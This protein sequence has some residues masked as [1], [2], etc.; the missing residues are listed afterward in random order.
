MVALPQILHHR[1]PY[2]KLG[3]P[4][5]RTS[6]LRI[7]IDLL[8][9]CRNDD[10]LML[11]EVLEW[12]QEAVSNQAQVEDSS[13]NADA[14]I[15]VGIRNCTLLLTNGNQ[16]KNDLPYP[17]FSSNSDVLLERLNALPNATVLRQ[18]QGDKKRILNVDLIKK[19]VSNLILPCRVVVSG[20]S[21]FN[22]AVRLMLLE[23]KLD[24]DYIT[25]LEA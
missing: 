7:P 8:L 11:S 2:F 20:P 14:K 25:I 1:N 12:C 22:S 3:I 19:M 13:W 21:A 10:I 16:Q 24:E 9:S 18:E 6:Q 17:D 15:T 4:T 23:S 5:K